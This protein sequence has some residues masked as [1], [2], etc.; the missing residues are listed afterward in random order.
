M[1]SR[2]RRL[3]RASVAGSA[4]LVTAAVVA[5]APAA[6]AKEPVQSLVPQDQ[7]RAETIAL[8][9]A[10]LRGRVRVVARGGAQRGGLRCSAAPDLSDLTVTGSSASPLLEERRRF[11]VGSAVEVYQTPEQAR[12]SFERQTVPDTVVPC[13][14]RFFLARS[15]QGRLRLFSAT[16]APTSTFGERTVR[17]RFIWRITTARSTFVGRTDL[18]FVVD[19][20]VVLAVAFFSNPR[21][22]A[23]SEQQALVARIAERI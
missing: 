11:L 7:Q 12:S 1:R 14:G 22:L 13:L 21:Y 9:R 20:R 8:K 16:V 18:Y 23:A 10:D 4:C 17:Y 5:A 15:E 2:P 19:E 6:T 3:V